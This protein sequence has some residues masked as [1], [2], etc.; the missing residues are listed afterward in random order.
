MWPR[1]HTGNGL[2]SAQ[3]DHDNKEPNLLYY[4]TII[5][6]NT[7]LITK[8]IKL[9]LLFIYIYLSSLYKN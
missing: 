9:F 7:R 6:V 8:Q 5:T 3:H 2:G 1:A 4:F